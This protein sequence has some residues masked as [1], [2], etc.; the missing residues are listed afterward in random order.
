MRR[1][2]RT[3]TLPVDDRPERPQRLVDRTAACHARGHESEQQRARQRERREQPAAP[4]VE[5]DLLRA[6]EVVGADSRS[7]PTPAHASAMPTAAA[8]SG[9]QRAFGEQIADD[10]PRDAPSA[11]RTASSRRRLRD[12]RDRAD[13]T[14][15]RTRSARPARRPPAPG[16]PIGCT[17]PTT[18]VLQIHHAPRRPLVLIRRLPDR[19]QAPV[20]RAQFRRGALAARRA[21]SRAERGDE[22]RPLA[23]RRVATAQR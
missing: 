13:S 3:A 17:S 9:E 5:R 2:R 6:R 4:A 8:P 23:R 18:Y 22:E 1:S 12:A 15:S 19:K 16:P 11:A 14:R 21:R 7:R 10:A 20:D